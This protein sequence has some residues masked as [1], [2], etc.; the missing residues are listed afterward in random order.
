MGNPTYGIIVFCVMIP[1]ALGCETRFGKETE[2][3][4]ASSSTYAP[5]PHALN[6]AIAP[7][8]PTGDAT[9]DKLNAKKFEIARDFQATSAL[10]K[11]ILVEG[12]RQSFSVPLPG[13]PICHTFVAAGADAVKNLQMRIS[14]PQGKTGV[15]ERSKTSTAA[16]SNF[17]P[18]EPGDYKLTV[19][20][21][22]KGGKFAVQ[23]F[24]IAR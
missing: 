16:I 14:T 7:P 19:S 18:A 21:K 10:Y 2:A 24:S 1:I 3:E 20:T 17:C 13:P 11:D 23:V 5:Q 9:T 4:L 12:K 8:L 22:G 6:R 15:L